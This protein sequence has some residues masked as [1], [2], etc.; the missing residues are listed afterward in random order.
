MDRLSLQAGFCSKKLGPSARAFFEA[1]SP[2]GRI[3]RVGL[4]LLWVCWVGL[5]FSLAAGAAAQPER[6]TE[7]NFDSYGL[8]LWVGGGLLLL[9][10]LGIPVVMLFGRYRHLVGER[11]ELK[12]RIGGL[13]DRQW[14]LEVEVER[15]RQGNTA[16]QHQLETEV[17][18]LRQDVAR[19]RG[20]EAEIQRLQQSLET[21]RESEQRYRMITQQLPAGIFMTDLQGE[22]RY[23]NDRWCQM[24]GLTAE[25]AAGVPWTQA[26]HPDEREQ[27][28]K[29]WRQ[30]VR[31]G[32]EFAVDHRFRSLSG[33]TTWL[34]TRAVPLR[35]RAGRVTHYLG[36]NTDIADLK[37]TEETLRASEAR[38]RSYFELP[39]VG[40][41]LIGPDKRW[42]E[43]NDRLCDLLGYQRSQLLRLSWAEL[44]YPDDL[45][46]D[47]AQFD[48]MMNRRIDG[49]SL[50][51]RFLRQ[52]GA[53][54]HASV[55]TRCV[56]RPNGVVDYFVA[57]IQDITERKQAEEHIQHLAHFDVLTGL[58][59]RALLGDRLEQAVLRALRDRVQVGVLLVDLDHFKRIN[60]T[61]GHTVGDQ[62]LR[63]VA[64][65]L[66]D[67]V[68]QGDTISRQGGDEFA[69]VL[70]DLEENDGAARMAERILGVVSE[71]YQ[72]EDHEL[73]INCSVGI[74]LCPRDGRSAEN[75]LKNADSALYR[76]KDLGRNSYQFYLSGATIIARERLNLENSLRHAVERQQ[77]ELYYQPKWDFHIGAITGAEAL[78]RWNHPELGLL[79]P[80]RFIPIAED[81]GLVLPVGEWVLRTAVRTIGQLHKNSY[82]G[83]RIAVN[84][85]ARQ[86]RQSD[87]TDL[88]KGLLAETGFEP[89][90]LELELTEGILMHHTED[91]IAALRAFK[92]MGVRIAI[93]DFGTGYSSLGYL[94]RFPV[95]VLKI[96]RS[97]VTDLPTSDSNAAI[98][99]A[100]VT[101]AHGLGLEVVA[102][103]VETLEHVEFLRAHGCDQGQGY[104]FGRPLP[105]A[106]FQ[107]LLAHDRLRAA[108]V[109]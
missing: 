43:V 57:V 27:V 76:A 109:A 30:A 62:L 46:T 108:A 66:Q 38:F 34:D 44:T 106:E 50:E 105:F 19:Q 60:D 61:L 24:T 83:F 13:N 78:V 40:I 26:V 88:V 80:A 2:N 36:A 95:D 94:Q 56:R 101:L 82:P 10:M 47:L 41:A 97:F 45:A 85:S 32:S 37:R 65:R 42:W 5:T 21:L 75:L 70:P 64:K 11:N 49:Y 91:N 31:E 8:R 107:N 98:V 33:R 28:L 87:L 58:P 52:D 6:L 22:C 12:G 73:H 35:D 3:R 79:P 84:L 102:E 90:C 69:I 54:L 53:L 29:T 74:S 48:R 77:L 96:D 51:K 25:Q 1:R 4:L 81:S 9:G 23:V 100:I 63:E 55:S 39:L 59:N 15:W 16:R 71:P 92:T 67:C 7:S 18:Q 72:I 89:A 103:G 17:H 20:L 104:Y 86:F 68:R 99:D 14:E 93:D